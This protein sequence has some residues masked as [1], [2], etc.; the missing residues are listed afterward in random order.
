MP[1]GLPVFE[2]TEETMFK[3]F[4]ILWL[5][6]P[7]LVMEVQGLAADIL[8]A[9]ETPELDWQLVWVGPLGPLG[10]FGPFGPFGPFMLIFK[11]ATITE[12]TLV[13]CELCE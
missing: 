8:L 6:L 11:F 10:T 1:L 5:V 12:A 7:K 9:V 4:I 2:L 13:E 3:L